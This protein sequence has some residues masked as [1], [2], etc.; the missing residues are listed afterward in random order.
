MIAEMR[1]QEF[2]NSAIESVVIDIK[3]LEKETK[4]EVVDSFK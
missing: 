2:K 4:N 1:C 3:L